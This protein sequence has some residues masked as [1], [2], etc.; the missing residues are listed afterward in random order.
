MDALFFI[1]CG[2]WIP[3]TPCVIDLMQRLGDGQVEEDK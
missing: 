2:G 3:S 1:I